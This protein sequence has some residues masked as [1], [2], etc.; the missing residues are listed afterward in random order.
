MTAY[1]HGYDP[2]EQV[3]LVDQATTLSDLLHHDTR[4]PDGADVL[5]VGCGVGAQTVTLASRSP[6]ALFTSIDVSPESLEAARARVQAAGLRNVTF[7]QADVFDAPFAEASFDHIFVCFVLEHLSRPRDALRNL[8][9]ILKP[10]GT[11]TVIEGD[12]GSTY[13]HPDNSE[14][15]RAVDCLVE[16]QARAGGNALIGR[17][18]FPLLTSAG[19]RTVSVSPRMVYVDGSRPDWIEGFTLNTFTAMVEGVRDPAIAAG[20]TDA[21]SF[22]RGIA[23]LRRTAQHD[24]VF[25]Y[26]FFKATAER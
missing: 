23:A 2:R 13:F 17:E 14:A 1:V 6:G 21:D 24:G 19:L 26:T 8:R 7:R 20:L 25:C 3:R 16:L 9:L 5:E 10:G 18:L 4:Y 22:D 11:L 15:R 12:H